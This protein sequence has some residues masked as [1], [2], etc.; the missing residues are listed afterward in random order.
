MW[1][2]PAAARAAVH[3]VQASA[4]RA[5][6]SPSSA[7]FEK[8]LNDMI[9]IMRANPTTEQQV[10]ATCLAECRKELS[11]TDVGVKQQAVLKL[12]YLNM[13]GHDVSWSA[14]HVVDLMSSARF[15]GKRIGFI[16]AAETFTDT[17]DVL[18]L[19]TNLFRKSFASSTPH[20]ASAAAGCLSRIATV[21]L[22]R[23]LIGDVSA[24]LASS[25]P[26]LRKKGV[27]CMYKLL[28]RLP[29]A[30]ISVFPRLRERLED[31]DPSVV[32][33]TVN[34]LT[35][36]ATENPKGYL[37]LAPALYK[38]LT[39]SSSN[40]TLIKV[41]K[42]LRQLV[43]HEPRLA[44][45]LVQ[46][47]THLIETT[48]AKS[49]QFECLHTVASTMASTQPELAALSARKLREFVEAPDPNLKSLGLLALSELQAA[50]KVL[51]EPCRDAVLACLDDEPTV[52]QAALRLIAGMVTRAS[53]PDLVLKLISQVEGAPSAY[54]DEVVGVI[55]ACCRA[56]GFA[57]VPS[58]RWLVKTLFAVAGLASATHGVEVARLLLEVTLRVPAVRAFASEMSLECVEC[59]GLA[60][61]TAG[62]SGEP[63]AE[64]ALLGAAYVLG[65]HSALL[66]A[67]RLRTAHEALLAKGIRGFGADA[68]ASCIQAALRVLTQ[69]PGA[70]EA[71]AAWQTPLMHTTAF[72]AS[73]ASARRALA[74]FCTST[75]PEVSERAR[76]MHSLLSLLA[77]GGHPDE[78]I[79][80]TERA[81]MVDALRGGMD[82][83]LK[84]VA[85][86]AQRKVRPPAGLDLTTP[87]YTPTA[88]DW[89]A[90]GLANV[91]T[92][93]GRSSPAGETREDP[94]AGDSS[95][96]GS[97]TA[98]PLRLPPSGPY[99]LAS[100][101]G[102]SPSPVLAAG[103][104]SPSAPPQSAT[105]G[106]DAAAADASVAS[107][108]EA[109]PVVKYPT[110][111]AS[112]VAA[113]LGVE[114]EEEEATVNMEEDMP[115]GADHSEEEEPTPSES[116][117]G[118]SCAGAAGGS[119]GQG[120]AKAGPML[121]DLLGGDAPPPS[122]CN[123]DGS[124][125]PDASTK[126]R[127]RRKHR[128]E[129]ARA[130]PS[131]A[132]L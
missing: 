54:R 39:T 46:P 101:D 82:A 56:D 77:S 24:M 49:L 94:S 107:T 92:G 50:D 87:I 102:A 115:D 105:A 118:P 106:A 11:S 113:G 48:P 80:P 29:E 12:L 128:E 66:P 83:Q 38:V 27:L 15:R 58:F 64:A 124:A 44:K 20:E 22:A 84:A 63:P 79:G 3:N 13:L 98:M 40:W 59:A 72:D 23:D 99:Y 132:L 91:A 9:K 123:F 33:C 74:P 70:A 18:L 28:Q 100:T 8:S 4:A 127:R 121:V 62:A 2:G 104:E 120:G 51:L 57:H 78:D 126:R 61:T 119:T 81:R 32:A 110:G 108:A 122:A 75:H 21:D 36:L 129:G 69:S 10:V 88:A 117:S 17:T 112:L 45:K 125:A 71:A 116:S 42:F 130:P 19:T 95:I 52:R 41:V 30:L 37:G 1:R 68:Q 60:S 114:E 55:L 103:D 31:T 53:L 93:D 85:P 67:E 47:L 90:L 26:L 34:V 43:P 6:R 73:I 25:K 109:R 97:S 76:G 131:D 111:Y 65:E 5:L 86:K 7:M 16:A 89:A 14:F 96:G 35:E